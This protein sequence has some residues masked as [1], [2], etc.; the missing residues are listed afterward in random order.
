LLFA[1]VTGLLA[2]CGG[3][4]PL[5]A[6]PPRPAAGAA[7]S[8]SAP[9]S[10][11]P[12][13]KAAAAPEARAPRSLEP[14]WPPPNLPRVSSDWCIEG[15]EALDAE[16][17]Y[18]LPEHPSDTLLIYLHGIVPPSR[19]SAQKTK[20]ESIV[21]DAALRAGVVA[22]LPRGK[23]GLAPKATSDWWGWPTSDGLY[24]KYGD[25]LAA[26]IAR[27]QQELQ[28]ALGVTF[29]HVYVAGSSSGA[30]FAAELAL[31]GGID[32]DGFG[33]MSGGA[34]SAT[35]G[36]DA[37]TPKPFYI[38]YGSYDTVGTSA[39]SLGRTLR[40]AGWPVRISEHKVGHGAQGVY[41][42]EA[43]EFWR[44]DARSAGPGPEAAV[45]AR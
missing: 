18:V 23:R 13:T 26:R 9:A 40:R 42:D 15:L 37:L 4:A 20:V 16:T 36:L 32:A 3:R 1:V 17:C 29:T 33:A 35:R 6:G 39:R 43:F 10:A 27:T 31:H 24:D 41:L 11:A 25:A 38:G 28:S 14:A 19:Q 21:R 44:M 12:E 8:A 45:P 34:G 30:Y 2:A 22:L 5:P 7:P